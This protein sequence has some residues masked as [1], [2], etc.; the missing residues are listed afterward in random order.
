MPAGDLTCMYKTDSQEVFGPFRK[1]NII[2]DTLVFEDIKKYPNI[3]IAKKSYINKEIAEFVNS[4]VESK[5]IEINTK[6]PKL[7][8][9]K[10]Y[11]QE[12]KDTREKSPTK[13]IVD[14]LHKITV[15][16]IY[17]MKTDLQKIIIGFIS[18]NILNEPAEL[19]IKEDDI[20]SNENDNYK[21]RIDDTSLHIDGLI[22]ENIPLSNVFF[23][24][25][26]GEQF[27]RIRKD[28]ISTIFNK[29][30]TSYNEK[31]NSLFKTIINSIPNTMKGGNNDNISN[32]NT[33]PHNEINIK[34]PS[35]NSNL[36]ETS[37]TVFEQTIF[38][39]YFQNV[40]PTTQKPGLLTFH[41]LCYFPKIIFMVYSLLKYIEADPQLQTLY[42]A[43][44]APLKDILVK[45]Y[46]R[47]FSDELNRI[48]HDMVGESVEP[49]YEGE[50][51]YTVGDLTNY[52]NATAVI[53]D[54]AQQMYN[55]AGLF[56]MGEEKFK[57]DLALFNTHVLKKEPGS[58]FLKIAEKDNKHD[59]EYLYGRLFDAEYY[60]CETKGAYKKDDGTYGEEFNSIRVFEKFLANGVYSY[61]LEEVAE[62]V[63][64]PVA[65]A[66]AEPVQSNI[67]QK[68]APGA[69]KKEDVGF[70][71][72]MLGTL[73]LGKEEE[74]E[75]MPI[76]KLNFASTNVN[77]NPT[78]PVYGGAKKT[79]K[80]SSSAKRY[81]KTRKNPKHRA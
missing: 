34:Y 75:P 31:L 47:D 2:E 27:I 17:D 77:E 74:E 65:D 10:L 64:E 56:K 66:D 5:I 11:Y 33:D 71:A 53:I 72:K 19:H 59:I 80:R 45:F 7:T 61:G 41:M 3:D 15:N 21:G 42:N 25:R 58:L 38:Q 13:Y 54:I 79:R 39:K 18:N 22:W 12:N 68:V 48:F 44:Y 67:P 63:A 55:V 60:V 69:P 36:N 8:D 40:G 30:I 4:L 78:A 29:L 20:V 1:N 62:P 28:N 46:E 76:R 26:N 43:S 51:T 9:E 16:L 73:G 23:I 52:D 37:L 81:K 6:F 24:N 57:A 49:T 32:N 70:L 35:F 50:G 14:K